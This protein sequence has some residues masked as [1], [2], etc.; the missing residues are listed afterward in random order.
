MVSGENVACAADEVLVS[1][2]C[3]SGAP[4]GARCPGSA[5]ALCMRK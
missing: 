1:L 5:T 4:D 3:S 2:V